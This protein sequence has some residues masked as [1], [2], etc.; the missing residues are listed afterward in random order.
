MLDSELKAFD[1]WSTRSAENESLLLW[2]RVGKAWIDG[3]NVGS[4]HAQLAFVSV[5]TCSERWLY[6]T[7]HVS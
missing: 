7:R 4:F 3:P 5:C 1:N 6:I 2:R